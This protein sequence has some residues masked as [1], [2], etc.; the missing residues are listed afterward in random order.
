MAILNIV[1]VD[2]IF[3]GGATH[4]GNTIF[5]LYQETNLL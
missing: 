5:N 3:A 1:P 4:P 2:M